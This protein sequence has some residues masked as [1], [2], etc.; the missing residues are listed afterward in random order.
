MTWGSGAGVQLAEL[1]VI[2]DC[3]LT[4]PPRVDRADGVVRSF[5]ARI[6]PGASTGWH[7]HD[8]WQTGIV[9]RG[10]LRHRTADVVQYHEPGQ[11]L[12]EAPFVD[13]E[14]TNVSDEELVLVFVA[15]QIDDCPLVTPRPAP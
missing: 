3:R 12:V 14:A 6:P 1:A 13:H 2:D 4:V 9:A 5:V 11:V 8:A 15:A 10:R 7:R